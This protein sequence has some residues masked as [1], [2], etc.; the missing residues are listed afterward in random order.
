MDRREKMDSSDPWQLRMFQKTLKKK[1]KLKHLTAY[2]G[3]LS[4]SDTCLLVTCGDNNGA[5][6]YFLRALGG[7]WTWAE[8][9]D[10]HIKE[11]EE[12]L[13]EQV[14]RIDKSTCGLPF[15]DSYFKYV[16]I[17]DCH[18]HLQDP[19]IFNLELARVTKAGGRVVVSVP[20]GNER[21]L[22]VRIKRFIG[23]TEE[24]YGH[25][26]IGYEI[27]KL[28]TMLKEVGLVP[29][30]GSSYSKFFTEMLELIINFAYVKI[31]AKRS[32]VEVGSGTIA[33]TSEKQLESVSKVYTMYSIIY[34]FFWI[35]SQLDALLFFT[36]GYAVVVGAR[37][38]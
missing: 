8:M 38:E 4:K 20:N 1:L 11:I 3:D 37:K 17:I 5:M 10:D 23:M 6:N 30:S 2:I 18:E 27:K 35:I 33:P 36:T 12:L 22:A 34:P 32:K 24:V 13:Q 26:V 28:D 21:Q 31:L 9:E 19:H 16:V 25:V 14:V 7:R 15:P 29:Y